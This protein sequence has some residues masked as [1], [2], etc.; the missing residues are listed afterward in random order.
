MSTSESG[1]WLSCAACQFS[2]EPDLHLQQR[3]S[4]RSPRGHH[5]PLRLRPGHLREAH[6]HHP[7]ALGPPGLCC[8][9]FL[10]LVLA[11]K[12]GAPGGGTILVVT[13]V[14]IS[15]P[16]TKHLCEPGPGGSTRG[17]GQGARRPD[18]AGL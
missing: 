6:P 18:A 2:L 8:R 13:F 5:S 12:A 3:S 7:A 17:E 9:L 10:R 15:T 4:S 16:P 11:V 1:A 14:F